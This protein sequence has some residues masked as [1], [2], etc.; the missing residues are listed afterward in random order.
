MSQIA[1]KDDNNADLLREGA[2]DAC[3]FTCPLGFS[4]S[5]PDEY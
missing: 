4:F 5:E 2:T 3:V 1:G